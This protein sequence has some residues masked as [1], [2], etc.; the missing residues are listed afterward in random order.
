MSEEVKGIP[1]RKWHMKRN[2][3]APLIKGKH[4][5]LGEYYLI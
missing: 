1:R 2:E 4:K 3:N 5:S